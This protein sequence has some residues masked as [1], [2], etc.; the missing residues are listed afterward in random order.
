MAYTDIDLQTFDLDIFFT[1]NNKLIHVASAGGYLPKTLAKTD[2]YNQFVIEKMSTESNE[3]EIEINPNL[4]NIDISSF[5]AL[6]SNG[7]Y[8]Y[9]KS[10]L[11]NFEDMTFHLVA[12]PKNKISSKLLLEKYKITAALIQSNSTIPESFEPFNLEDYIL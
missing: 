11:G 12:K 4:K 3:F 8:S 6:A 2:I 9:D 1:D 10:H 5:T 7:F